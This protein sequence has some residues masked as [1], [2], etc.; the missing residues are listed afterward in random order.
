MQA[1]HATSDGPYVLARLGQRRAKEGAYVWKSLREA[2]AVI[3]NGT[4]VPVER[5]DPMAGIHAAVTRKMR[6]GVAFFPEQCMTR[7]QALRSYTL[8]AAYAA[9]EEDIKG[10]ITVGKLADIAVLSQDI[11]TVPEEEI[12]KTR[13]LYTIVG[14]K[15][16]HD[17]TK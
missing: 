8:D 12:L 14:G 6:N 7:Q 2:G 4:D 13:V 5:V 15:V 1:V 3:S 10:S 9:F 11:L 17:S 16:V